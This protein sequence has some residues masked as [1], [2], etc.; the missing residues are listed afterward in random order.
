MKNKILIAFFVIFLL[1]FIVVSYAQMCD[2]AD[3]RYALRKA[4]Y[5][6]FTNSS[7]PQVNVSEIKDLLHFYLSI[8]SG[9]V[10]V[11]C[12]DTGSSGYTY[13]TIVQNASNIV[14][15]IP[16]CSDNTEFGKCS[17]IS[18]PKYCYAG[19]LIDRCELCGCPSN[20]P[21]CNSKGS[22]AE[23]TKP[24][25]CNVD[26]DCG[27]SNYT[28]NYF[29]SGGDVYRNYISYTCNNSKTT[30]SFCSNSTQAVLIDDC[31]TTETCSAGSSSCSQITTYPLSVFKSGNGTGTVSSS[32]AGINCG[33]T[34]SASYS[35]GTYVN[36]TA[37]P[38]STSV[39]NDDP[40][41][42][43]LSQSGLISFTAASCVDDN[44]GTNAWHTDSS[45]AGAWLKMDLGSG[46]A[47]DYVKARIYA[48]TSGYAGSYNIQYSDN[49]S[50]YLNAATGFVPSAAGWNEK[51]WSNVGAHRYWR[52]Y[53]SNT[54]GSGSWLNEFEMYKQGGWNSTFT[55][56]SGAC[57]GT[58]VCTVLMTSNKTANAAFS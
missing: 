13:S 4:L 28:G 2:V 11:N 14:V 45:T 50:T 30:N 35:S 46:N 38:N 53:L 34:C 20:M 44:T 21:Q 16:T 29:C 57:S 26:S 3:T 36:L 49:D 43:M 55:G 40:T 48:Q 19:R 6:Y 33:T 25:V 58:G 31:N 27:N 52:F 39:S 54:P 47:K 23:S 42:A 51:T 12:S 17:I 5:D 24:I 1:L 15:S 41:S 37:T 10:T 56:W 7:S 22:C 8:P 18:K 32:P 9:S